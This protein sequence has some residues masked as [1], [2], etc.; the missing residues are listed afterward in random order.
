[1]W[2]R[3]RLPFLTLTC[4]GV[5]FV[6]AKLLFAPP[7]VRSYDPKPYTFTESVPLPNW[8]LQASQPLTSPEA[9]HAELAAQRYQYRQADAT[10]DIEMRYLSGSSKVRSFIDSYTTIPTDPTIRRSDKGYYGVLA[11]ED[12]AYLSA[13]IPPRGDSTFTSQQF[14]QNALLHDIRPKRL[15]SWWVGQQKLIDKRCLWTHLSTPIE[16]NSVDAAY[17]ILEEAWLPWLE[18]WQTNFPEL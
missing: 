4:G 9:S 12:T 2:N 6:F 10:L 11:H 8:Q 14:Q 1:M 7:A 3:L 5:L 16:N 13:C 15:A 17:Q 18:W